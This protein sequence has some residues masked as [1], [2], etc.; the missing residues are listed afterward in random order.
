MGE[1]TDGHGRGVEVDRAWSGIGGW[2]GRWG[3]R[4]VEKRLGQPS[5]SFRGLGWSEQGVRQNMLDVDRAV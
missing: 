3:L 1:G 2:A 4:K 5:V